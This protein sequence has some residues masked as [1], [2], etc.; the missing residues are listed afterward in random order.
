MPTLGLVL[1]KVNFT[2]DPALMVGD[3]GDRE[4]EQVRRAEHRINP[5]I[6]Q[7][8][9]P[10]LAFRLQE[11]SNDLDLIGGKRRHLADRFPLV[12]E[13]LFYLCFLLHFYLK[14]K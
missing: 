6:K 4:G 11:G 8:Q 3:I 2:H 12:P 5:D 13:P 9:I 14:Q 7:R 10:D 1:S